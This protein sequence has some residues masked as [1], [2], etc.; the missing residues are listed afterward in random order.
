M[1]QGVQP[2][3]PGLRSPQESVA[4]ADYS[5][6]DDSVDLTS[7]D[8]T[9]S[10]QPAAGGSVHRQSSAEDLVEESFPSLGGDE[11][12]E[13]SR[14]IAASSAPAGRRGPAAATSSARA[15]EQPLGRRAADAAPTPA[16]AASVS[17]PP[18]AR[19]ADDD[20]VMPMAP[21]TD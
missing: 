20:A 8:F 6:L 4:T 18:S 2:Q 5:V 16:G 12:D 13:L 14:L 3:P 21:P 17:T 19:A 11:E 7:L 9:E 10:V 1:R 15:G